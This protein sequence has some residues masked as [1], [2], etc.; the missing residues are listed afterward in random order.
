MRVVNDL[1]QASDDGHVSILSLLDLSAT[2]DTID[3]V[4][5]SQRLSSTSSAVLELF[6]VGLSLTCQIA[7][8]LSL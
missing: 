4:I 7:R 3:H 2:F 6:L 1:L 8:S 5:L